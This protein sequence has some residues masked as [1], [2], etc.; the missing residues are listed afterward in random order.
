LWTG[1]VACRAFAPLKMKAG[2][3]RFLPL[4]LGL[5]YFFLLTAGVLT[6]TRILTG[7][8]SSFILQA[9]LLHDLSA[10]SKER[11][12]AL[13]PDYILRK[14]N[15]S[16]ES[17]AAY[18]TPYDATEL[19]RGEG[20]GLRLTKDYGE[21]AELRAKW[22]EVVPA[23]KAIYLRHR[24]EVFKRLI[25][26]NEEHV[27]APYLESSRRFGGYDLND[28]RVHYYLRAAFYKLRDTLLFRGFF[29]LLV[30]LLLLCVASSRRLRDDFE[31]VFVLTLSG[32]LYGVAYFFFAPACGFRFFWWTT[33]AALVSLCFSASCAVKRRQARRALA[34]QS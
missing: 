20:A 25:G 22:L 7:G 6:T 14:E 13:F 26:L 21:I 29:W 19:F 33:L 4:A 1:V 18:Y 2:G 11:G 30:S 5:A 17:A 16:P 3:R 8:R 32:S 9:V 10:I 28:W 23:N 27:C 31:I 24:W 15:F 12:E 34:A